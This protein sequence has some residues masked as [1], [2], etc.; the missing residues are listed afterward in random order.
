M[1]RP[2]SLKAEGWGRFVM[3]KMDRCQDIMGVVSPRY[4][5]QKCVSWKSR[6][7]FSMFNVSS[8]VGKWI[9][10]LTWWMINIFGIFFRSFLLFKNTIITVR[11]A[12]IPTDAIIVDKIMTMSKFWGLSLR[13]NNVEISVAFEIFRKWLGIVEIISVMF[14]TWS[15]TE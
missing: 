7:S 15:V 8:W 1:I 3:L 5:G 14:E 2:S 6:L 4:T 11:L 12:T 13:E 9:T 10:E